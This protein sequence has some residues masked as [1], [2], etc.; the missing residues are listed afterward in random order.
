MSIQSSIQQA[1]AAASAGNPKAGIG[2]LREALKQEPQNVEVWLALAEIVENPEQAN[3]C[4]ERVLQIDPNNSVARQKLYGEQ[5]NELDF[6]FETTEDSFQ[7]LESSPESEVDLDFS[8]MSFPEQ[9]VQTMPE[10]A[11]E[12]SAFEV[13]P[14]PPV[15]EQPEKPK[16]PPAK[17]RPKSKKATKKKKKGL[18]GVEIAMIVVIVF[19]CICVCIS[20]LAAAGR[21]SLLEMEIEPTDVPDVVTAVIYANIRAS[22]AKDFNAYMATIHPDSPVYDSTARELK[23]AFSDEFTLT[24]WVSDI[25]IIDQSSNRATV[26]FV[27]TTRLKSGPISFRDN[28][29]EGEMDLRK[30]EGQWKIYNQDVINVEYLD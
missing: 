12:I 6:L 10:P 4:L 9:P 21:N 3:Q 20:G 24:Y 19:L 25:Y 7:D 16:K 17:R 5:P 30:D 2:I 14:S 22:N 15:V 26:H 27:L 29:V 1:K 13:Q 18:S 23:K 8:K 28:R 11:P